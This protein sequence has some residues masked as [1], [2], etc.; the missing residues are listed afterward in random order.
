MKPYRQ[1]EGAEVTPV[2][3][4]G[5]E[6]WEVEAITNHNVLTSRSKKKK[7]VVEFQVQWKGH[8]E[9][10]WHEFTDCEHSIDLVQKY[11]GSCT[12]Q[13]RSQIYK[14]LLPAEN[15][16]LTGVYKQEALSV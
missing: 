1:R 15:E 9:P 11:L 3:V 4:D 16:W 12:R 10:S 6:E 7:S 14:V 8:A 5:A 2:W 13:V